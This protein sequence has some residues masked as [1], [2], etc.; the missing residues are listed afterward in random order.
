LTRFVLRCCLSVLALPEITADN[1]PADEPSAVA[2]WQT[3]LKR[4]ETME[5]RV[6]ALER[7]ASSRSGGITRSR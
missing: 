6:D 1:T 3:L 7:E 5:R 2:D 4:I